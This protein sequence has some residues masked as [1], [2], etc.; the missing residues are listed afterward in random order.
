MRVVVFRE[1]SICRCCCRLNPEFGLVLQT[2]RE[3]FRI[4]AVLH[5]THHVQF[6]D[7]ICRPNIKTVFADQQAIRTLHQLIDFIYLGQLVDI[8]RFL[9]R[10]STSRRRQSVCPRRLRFS[11]CFSFCFQ[12]LDRG[13]IAGQRLLKNARSE[14][15]DQ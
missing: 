6:A 10:Q 8:F 13:V 4:I 11:A 9:N 2:H 12:L 14:C 15:S 3:T 7:D 1:T 5:I